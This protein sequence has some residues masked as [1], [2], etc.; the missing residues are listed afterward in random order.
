M[1][2]NDSRYKAGLLTYNKRLWT[3]VNSYRHLKYKQLI[4]GHEQN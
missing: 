4:Y 3:L 2:I 1:A